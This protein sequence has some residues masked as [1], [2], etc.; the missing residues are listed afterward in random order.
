MTQNED[1]N[2]IDMLARYQRAQSLE[3]GFMTKKVAF[4]TTLYPNWIGDTDCFWYQRD[5]RASYEYCLVDAQ[6]QT[7]QI[8]FDHQAL[9]SALSKATGKEVDAGN[10]PLGNFEISLSPFMLTFEAYDR[11]WVYDERGVCKA[12]DGFSRD[13]KVSPDGTKVMFTRDYNLWVRDVLSGEEKPLTQDGEKFN[14][15][16]ATTTVYGYQ[17]QEVTLEA[18]WSAD[19]KRIFTQVIDTR[20]V[21]IATPLV[22]HVPDSGSLH[23]R[24][25]QADRRVGFADDEHIECWEFL[26]IDVET[27]HIQKADYQ[28]CPVYYPHYAGYFTGGRGWWG[29]DNRR[30]YFTELERGGK[31]AR[32]VEFDTHTG[33]TKILIEETS[34]WFVVLMPAVSHDH[35]LMMPLLETNELIWYSARSGSAHFYLYDLD[36][37]ELK[38]PITQGDWVIRNGVHFDPEKRE[39]IIQTA[40]RIEGR[41]PYYRDIC[42]VNIDTGELSELLSTDHEYVV[43]D[44]RGKGITANFGV[45]PT[46]NYMVTTRSRADE[47][48]VSYLLDRDGKKVMTLETAD[49]SGLPDGWQWPEPVMLKAADGETDIYGVVFRPSDFSPDKSYP[50]VNCT[51]YFAPAIG[52][53]TNDPAFGWTYMSAAAIAE[54]GFVTVVICGRGNDY[55]RDKDFNSYQDSR[56]PLNPMFLNNFNQEDC[57]AGIKQLSERY[58]YMDIQR[59]GVTELNSLASALTGLLLYPEFYK[60][61]VTRNPNA[62]W[63]MTGA[64]GMDGTGHY[65]ALEEFAENLQGKLLLVAGMLDSMIPVSETFRIIAALQAANKTFDMLVLPKDGHVMSSYAVRRSWDYLVKHLLEKEPPVDFKLSLDTLERIA[66][67]EKRL[68]PC[69]DE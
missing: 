53:F 26:S 9:A 12:I 54:L 49:V 47:V 50:I 34:D 24:I 15:Y 19:S 51:Y 20:Q 31:I 69:R 27:G 22:E 16:A 21:N 32:L 29:K 1:T 2:G 28:P 43:C 55:L 44:G 63:R 5:D 65:P 57:V 14:F 17:T 48:P 35:M 23:P 60:V 37:G 61:G 36:S 52:S 3:Q 45:S 30:A 56:L 66:D 7:N 6:Q 4:N 67:W 11:H 38:H 41:N 64:L 10:L 39:L 40:G 8:A 62:N 46:A 58:P 18:I 59:V 33:Q 42:R 68:M 13:E 25:I